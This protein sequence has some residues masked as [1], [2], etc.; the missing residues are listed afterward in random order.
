MHPPRDDF[1]AV[2]SRW[3][4]SDSAFP[5][6]EGE[7]GIPSKSPIAVFAPPGP[8]RERICEALRFLDCEPMAF[9][10]SEDLVT[11][12]QQ[13]ARFDMLLASFG[14]DDIHVLSGA[15]V[16]RRAAGAQ[17]PILLMVS[18]TQLSAAAAFAG[19]AYDDFIMLPSTREELLA[20][21]MAFQKFSRAP[22]MPGSF[23]CGNYH[24]QPAGRI[25]RF[26]DKRVRLKPMEFDLALYLFRNPEYL[27]TR[28]MLY[29]AVWG[30]PR[31]GS[32]TRTLDVHIASLRKK[33]SIGQDDDCDLQC[34]RNVGYQLR[35]H[36]PERMFDPGE[37]GAL[38]GD[39][40]VLAPETSFVAQRPSVWVV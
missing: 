12:L 24:F 31:S 28:E 21:V 38:R 8:D 25:V 30:G 3:R 16:L 19:G 40:R 13:G 32:D 6:T 36:V 20:R 9:L 2:K 14:G 22:A 35:L 26:K 4:P 5:Q 11:S 23:S 39:E 18:E 34:V 37:S 7:R 1:N 33:L 15:R 27:H 17:M 10:R 29:R